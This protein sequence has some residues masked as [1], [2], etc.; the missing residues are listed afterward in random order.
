V[1]LFVDIYTSGKFVVYDDCRA[2]VII[3]IVMGAVFI[4][5]GIERSVRDIESAWRMR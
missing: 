1:G 3:A 5:L 4:V 2:L